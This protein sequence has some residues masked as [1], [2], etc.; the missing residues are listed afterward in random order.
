LLRLWEVETEGQRVWRASLQDS[1]TGERRGFADLAALA[2]FLAEQ[3]GSAPD[4]HDTL[5]SI[6]APNG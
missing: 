6:Q 4:S 1:G 2:L 5:V 3:T